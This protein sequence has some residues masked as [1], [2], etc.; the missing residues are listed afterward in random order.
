[1]RIRSISVYQVDVPL[2]HGDYKISGGRTVSTLDTTIVEI[3]TDDGTVGV[4]ESCPFGAA[5]DPVFADGIRAAVTLLA[6]ALI[7]ADPREVKRANAL[8]DAT[9]KGNAYAKSAIDIACW[10]ILGK[11]TGLPVY[12]LLGGLLTEQV[13]T[14]S[15]IPGGSIDDMV[16]NLRRSRDTGLRL[17]S[18]KLSGDAPT[19]V[20]R[21]RALAEVCDATDILTFDANGGMTTHS[22]IRFVNAVRDLDLYFEQPCAEYQDFLIVRQHCPHP[23][24]LDESGTSMRAI[25]EAKADGA[26]DVVKFKI[27]RLGGLTNSRLVRDFCVSLGLGVWIQDAG[28]SD[29]SSAAIAHLAHSTLPSALLGGLSQGVF[30]DL[31]VA[32]GAPRCEGGY[33]TANKNPGLGVEL[34]RDICA[35]P[36]ACYR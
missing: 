34:R 1:M 30:T 5:Y 28:G 36:V 22:A 3:E 18:A 16:D 26:C 33:M 19:D 35:E 20:E 8:M 23:M 14:N 27:S 13:R 29:L 21:A 11:S 6:P 10:D 7:G 25:A 9:L 17:H 4:G 31:S 24:I 15:S 32:T 2:R 12:I